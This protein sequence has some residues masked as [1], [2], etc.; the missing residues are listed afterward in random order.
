MPPEPKL[1]RLFIGISPPPALRLVAQAAQKLCMQQQPDLACA[2]V[3]PENMHLTLRFLGF[4][5]DAQVAQLKE[6]LPAALAERSGF[7]LHLGGFGCFPALAGARVLFWNVEPESALMELQRELESRIQALGAAPA[8]HPYYP[9]LTL[10]RIRKPM[11]APLSLP[12]PGVLAET[13]LRPW[14]V[15]QIELFESVQGPQGVV[16]HTLADFSLSA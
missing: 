6:I 10:G 7:E 4:Q 11:R 2:W 9:H 16:Y 14:T 1:K 13:Q 8:E 3:L 5:S 12:E 15:T